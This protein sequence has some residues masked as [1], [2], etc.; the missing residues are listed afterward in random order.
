MLL[1]QAAI[2]SH[3]GDFSEWVWRGDFW[4]PTVTRYAKWST[5][6]PFCE[7]RTTTRAARPQ[8]VRTCVL[9][10]PGYFLLPALQLS[11]KPTHSFR[12]T[13]HPPPTSFA[14]ATITITFF[15]PLLFFVSTVKSGLLD[16]YLSYL[17]LISIFLPVWV[18]QL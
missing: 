6:F 4:Q 12:L 2:K 16:L 14:I 8:P 1:D 18:H 3:H 5:S 17:D 13:L 15:I 7:L 10:D 11:P 9:P